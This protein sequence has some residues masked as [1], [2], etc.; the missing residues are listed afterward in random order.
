MISL[1]YGAN[2]QDGYYLHQLLTKKGYQCIGIS[3]SGNWLQGD[4]SDFHQVEHLTKTYHPDYIFH[5]AANST[6]KHQAIFD[7]HQ[8]IAKGT[9]NILEAVYKYSRQTKVFIAGSGLQFKNS[10]YP[11]SESDRFDPTSPYAISRIYSAYL[12]RYYRSLGIQ[13]YLGYLFHHESPLRQPSHIS[14]QIINK[15][16]SV[17]TGNNET[18]HL[19]D[20][21]VKK[22][23]AFAGDIV[24]GI[25]TLINQDTVFEATI[26]TGIA[27]SIQTWLEI[28]FEII[29]KNWNDFI[30][31]DKDFQPEYKCLVS[32]PATIFSLGWKPVVKIAELARIML[33]S[34]LDT[35]INY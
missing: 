8:C 31:I 13:T 25:L 1:I 10:G 7:N 4:V 34:V 2:G 23:W 5:L 15:V 20:I 11:I 12:A 17:A 27:Y 22:E 32:N 18:L 30:I 26:G 29:G 21:S 35:R 24:Q 14:Q 19:G 16:K 6:T 28:C 9:L 3:R 33:N